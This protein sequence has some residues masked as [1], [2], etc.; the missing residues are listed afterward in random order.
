MSHTPG[1]WTFYDP[2]TQ[3]PR[4]ARGGIPDKRIMVLHPDKERV[5]ACCETGHVHPFDG[6]IPREERKA[7]ARLMAAAPTML[8]ALQTV[9]RLPVARLYP[10]GPCLDQSDMDEVLAAIKLATHP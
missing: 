4:T 3:R 1:E 8:E 5:I 7:N 2:D 6:P 9:A 10:D